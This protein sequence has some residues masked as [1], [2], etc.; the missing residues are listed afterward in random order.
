L[1]V[2]LAQ[3]TYTAA[4]GLETTQGQCGR[5]GRHPALAPATTSTYAHGYPQPLLWPRCEASHC[6]ASPPLPSAQ[7]REAPCLRAPPGECPTLVWGRGSPGGARGCPPLAP[8]VVGSEWAARAS[9]AP[10]LAWSTARGTAR[11]LSHGAAKSSLARPR[12]RGSPR[13][14]NTLHQ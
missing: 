9:L 7:S 2:Y 12:P 13:G 11:E 14:A 1:P 4:Q 5:F 10:R 8:A 3:D 6:S